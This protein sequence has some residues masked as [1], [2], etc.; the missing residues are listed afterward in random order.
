MQWEAQ[1][2]NVH[3]TSVVTL[4]M[5]A[6]SHRVSHDC[7]KA[8]TVIYILVQYFSNVKKYCAS[9]LPSKRFI[10]AQMLKT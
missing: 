1:N 5:S 6:F 8:R 2:R 7:L 3:V 4:K 9:L 10:D